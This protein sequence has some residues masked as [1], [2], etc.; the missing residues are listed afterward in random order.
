ML[1]FFIPVLPASKPTGNIGRSGKIYQNSEKYLRFKRE[2]LKHFS[3]YDYTLKDSCHGILIVG[4]LAPTK[5]RSQD[6]GQISGAIYDILV[7][8]KVIQDD[9]LTNFSR[10]LSYYFRNPDKQG[11]Y[12][13]LAE[14]SDEWDR[15]LI[16]PSKA[17]TIIDIF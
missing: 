1:E 12:V 8:A 3:E 17:E 6:L 16:S 11:Y 9:R 5:K 2:S 7:T 14:S 4:F 13:G 15:C 10:S